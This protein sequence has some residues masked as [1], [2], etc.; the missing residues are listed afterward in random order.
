MFKVIK[1]SYDEFDAINE[2]VE[3][4]KEKYGFDV[5]DEY[6]EEFAPKYGVDPDFA[7]DVIYNDLDEY[8]F[9]C[10]GSELDKSMNALDEID[11]LAGNDKHLAE[12]GRRLG[13]ED[14]KK[15]LKDNPGVRKS[16]VKESEDMKENE[17]FK[18]VLELANKDAV[19]E[20]FYGTYVDS[21]EEWNELSDEEKVS[22]YF[23]YYEPIEVAKE[24]EIPIY[25]GS[26]Q[27]SDKS[28][29]NYIDGSQDDFEADY[30]YRVERALKDFEEENNVE[31]GVWQDGRSGRHI[32]IKATQENIL[33]FKELQEK[34]KIAEE[35][36][37]KRVNDAY[38]SES[39]TEGE[40]L[41][42]DIEEEPEEL[43]LNAEDV[44]D[45]PAE[46]VGE[47]TP[48]AII[49]IEPAEVPEEATEGDT[50]NTEVDKTEPDAKAIIEDMVNF[51]ISD[52]K[53]AIS[54]YT[55]R[56]GTLVN[57]VDSETYAK[58]QD[59]INGII[60]EE[61]HHID[62]LLDLYEEFGECD[63]E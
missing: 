61:Q 8:G 17:T 60:K 6:I 14:F 63:C 38:K 20:D 50:E 29:L 18:K 23:D 40:E 51:L 59:V 13:L 47:I 15:F 32:V 36:F 26:L 2:M 27:L 5:K 28:V 62:E 49:A 19:E 43:E 21:E 57:V 48:D 45:V 39:L 54:G 10:E 22:E 34:Y 30:G 4:I 16:V 24:L 33:R 11:K 42:L 9:K 3:E 35:D 58:I 31:D 37:I 52:E 46:E 12:I 41:E 53:E 56:L 7:K 44:I 55:S 1:E 25:N